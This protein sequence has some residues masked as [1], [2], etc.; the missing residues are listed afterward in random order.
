MYPGSSPIPPPRSGASVVRAV[1]A[2]VIAGCS[3]LV[4]VA[5]LYG[6]T[7]RAPGDA[8]WGL[9]AAAALISIPLALVIAW[10]NLTRVRAPVHDA[11]AYRAARVAALTAGGVAVAMF[12]AMVV[13]ATISTEVLSSALLVAF[14]F[15]PLLGLA[16]GT[17]GG[18]ATGRRALLA[19]AQPQAQP[20]PY[21]EAPGPALRPPL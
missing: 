9:I 14:A 18:A 20:D 15:G 11:G 8:E 13:A 10:L 5:A 2:L 19:A 12:V 7:N 3:A 1:A 6:E 16:L 21:W 4:A 17:W